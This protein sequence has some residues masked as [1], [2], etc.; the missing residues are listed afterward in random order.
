M[1]LRE[2]RL[3]VTERGANMPLRDLH[4]KH[5]RERAAHMRVLSLE[6]KDPESRRP[7]EKANRMI[8]R[9]WLTAPHG[10]LPPDERSKPESTHAG[11]RKRL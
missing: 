3:T 2:Q 7:H 11:D 1:R 10:G 9:N 6:V 5:C 8:T 4:E